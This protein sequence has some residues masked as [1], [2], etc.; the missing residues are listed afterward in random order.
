MSIHNFEILAKDII[1]EVEETLTTLDH[2]EENAVA[3]K[4]IAERA[5]RPGDDAGGVTGHR[6]APDGS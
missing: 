6:I 3:L 1:H 4:R 5:A 2:I